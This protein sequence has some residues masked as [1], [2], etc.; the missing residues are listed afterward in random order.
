LQPIGLIL[1]ADATG[2]HVELLLL[3]E[4][5][6]RVAQ[7]LTILP[8][9]ETLQSQLHQIIENAVDNKALHG[10]SPHEGST[11]GVAAQCRRSMKPEKREP[12]HK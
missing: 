9:R 11:A 5:N 3:D 2:E 10:N 7:F 12:S 8:P 4:D 6:I 1:C